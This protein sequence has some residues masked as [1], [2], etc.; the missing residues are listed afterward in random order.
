MDSTRAEAVAR[1]LARVLG[2]GMHTYGDHG[3]CHAV[4]QGHALHRALHLDIRLEPEEYLADLNNAG[5]L[6]ARA[7]EWVANHP[8][9]E[10]TTLDNGI[11]ADPTGNW[12]SKTHV[13]NFLLHEFQVQAFEDCP[14]AI[15]AMLVALGEL[16]A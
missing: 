12:N 1:A 3:V 7:R 13:H 10:W 5:R 16:E 15:E 2:D 9:P 11:I 8:E 4:G 14:A 6:L